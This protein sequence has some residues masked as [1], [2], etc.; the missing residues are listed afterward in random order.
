MKKVVQILFF[1]LI[2]V[3]AMN[4][5]KAQTYDPLAVQ[6]INDLIA[7][8]GLQA[9]SNAPETW[10]F[11]FWND[12]TPKQLT[13]LDLQSRNLSGS[14]SFE[15][16][17][18]LKKVFCGINNVTGLNLTNC[19]QLTLLVCGYNKLTDLNVTNCTQL[20][21][22]YCHDNLLTK[23]H[24]TDCVQ[25]YSLH[26]AANCL[27]EL[28]LNGLDNLWDCYLMGQKVQLTL[29][30]SEAGTYNLPISLNAPTF[31][32][33]AIQYENG[34]LIS[35]DS[36]VTSTFFTVQTNKA[37]FE[38]NGTMYFHYSTV[39]ITELANE[40][41]KVYPNPITKELNVDNG[42][43][44]IKNIEIYDV[45]GKKQKVENIKQKAEGKIE[46]DISHLPDGIYFVK[47]DTESG[48]VVR[49]IVKS[50]N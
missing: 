36:T 46:I 24:I 22:L 50:S 31:E 45:N 16:L 35:L 21:T 17:T 38:L 10:D 19:T 48:E 2:S 42:Q 1:A 30:K 33:K 32:N 37:G 47:M 39:G 49:K 9:I 40:Q 4:A 44:M 41:V 27:T 34:I 11:A 29:S 12:E 8:N 26:C 28:D 5:A 18:T 3:I 7:N 6:R 20:T 14:A 43:L 25:M 13:S 23:L 15:G